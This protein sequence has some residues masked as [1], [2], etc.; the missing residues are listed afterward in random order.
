MCVLPSLLAFYFVR[1][2]FGVRYLLFVSSWVCVCPGYSS[3]FLRVSLK[4]SPPCLESPPPGCRFTRKHIPSLRG[5]QWRLRHSVAEFEASQQNFSCE[6][7]ILDGHARCSSSNRSSAREGDFGHTPRAGER[8]AR[9][10]LGRSRHDLSRKVGRHC[11][12]NT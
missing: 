4:R 10:R 3:S 7:P 5:N 2:V 6:N 11:D 12:V 9:E 1:S 8:A